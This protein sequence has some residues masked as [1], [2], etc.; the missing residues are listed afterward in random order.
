MKQ[1]S[2]TRSPDRSAI[3][4]RVAVA[5]VVSIILVVGAAIYWGMSVARG[6]HQIA[7]A[8]GE[9]A[10]IHS[11]PRRLTSGSR[12]VL[13][14]RELAELSSY[15]VLPQE[16]GVDGTL[17]IL[18]GRWVGDEVPSALRDDTT[19]VGVM[20]VAPGNAEPVVVRLERT[21]RKGHPRAL[22]KLTPFAGG[23]R[24]Y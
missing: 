19:W 16:S 15:R 9:S 22:L 5:V 20:T 6:W 24:V 4:K 8:V 21:P 10:E 7:Q 3:F 2:P 14:E 12:V 1:I 23:F 11:T 13:G 17:Y 18:E